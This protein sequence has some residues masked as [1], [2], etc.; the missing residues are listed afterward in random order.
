MYLLLQS[1]GGKVCDQWN[2]QSKKLLDGRQMYS[3]I[4]ITKTQKKCSKN[5][6]I[7]LFHNI[8]DRT[9]NVYSV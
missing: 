9:N 2:L 4:K 8:V 6:L 3:N 7:L 5:N 1:V